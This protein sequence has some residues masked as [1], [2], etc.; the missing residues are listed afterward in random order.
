MDTEEGRVTF[1]KLVLFVAAICSFTGFWLGRATVPQSEVAPNRSA[2]FT[3]RQECEAYCD[4]ADAPLIE[5]HGDRWS[6]TDCIC[7]VEELVD[8]E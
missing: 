5:I 2:G 6:L 1:A 7:A 8:P 3:H 4:G